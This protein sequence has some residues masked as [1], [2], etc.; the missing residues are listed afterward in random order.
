MTE[1]REKE[2]DVALWTWVVL[3]P[4]ERRK[5]YKDITKLIRTIVTESRKEGFEE[6]RLQYVEGQLKGKDIDE[7]DYP[8][9]LRR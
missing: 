2:I 8:P 5:K 4:H 9:T 6:A 3:P 1:E 7:M